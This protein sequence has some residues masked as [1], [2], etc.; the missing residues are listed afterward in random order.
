ML[1]DE[2]LCLGGSWGNQ[3]CTVLDYIWAWSISFFRIKV[4]K[5]DTPWQCVLLRCGC[6]DLS[7]SC[8]SVWKKTVHIVRGWSHRALHFSCHWAKQAS[9]LFRR[10]VLSS[11]GLSLPLPLHFSQLRYLRNVTRTF[12][13]ILEEI[14]TGT[15]C[16]GTLTSIT[17][18]MLGSQ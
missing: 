6:N 8:Y 14:L 13:C 9:V 12:Q 15:L 17:C 2:E 3:W 18:C 10:Q 16:S 7:I 11:L 1:N 4:N 5:G